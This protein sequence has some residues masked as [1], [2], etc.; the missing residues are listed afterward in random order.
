MA[1]KV[2][3]RHQSFWQ[4]VYIAAIAAGN[5]PAGAEQMADMAVA[6]YIARTEG[7]PK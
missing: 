6:A 2:E 5:M 4:H 3:M 1:T 7:E